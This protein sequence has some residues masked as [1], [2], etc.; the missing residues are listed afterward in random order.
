MN[1]DFILAGSAGVHEV[2]IFNVNDGQPW[3]A[4]LNLPKS[5]LSID[6]MNTQNS[7]VFSG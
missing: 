7:V 4:V 1:E 5:V 3:G 6:Q 2:R